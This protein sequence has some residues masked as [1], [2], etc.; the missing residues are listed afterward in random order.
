MQQ[1]KTNL[2]VEK[3]VGWHEVNYVDHF[4]CPGLDLIPTNLSL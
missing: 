2:D 3:N 1:Y 4:I